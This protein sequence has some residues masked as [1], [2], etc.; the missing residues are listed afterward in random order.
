MRQA[1]AYRDD[2]DTF[3]NEYGDFSG[4]GYRTPPLAMIPGDVPLAPTPPSMPSLELPPSCPPI[5]Y[6]SRPYDEEM[7]IRKRLKE[8]EIQYHKNQVKKKK[9]ILPCYVCIL[10]VLMAMAAIYFIVYGSIVTVRTKQSV[11]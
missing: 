6:R 5:A 4:Y 1:D 2:R 8:Q 11:R 10:L 9:P 7:A 3:G